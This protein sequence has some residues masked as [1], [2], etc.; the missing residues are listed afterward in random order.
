MKITDSPKPSK[1][2]KSKKVEIV[3]AVAAYTATGA[4]QLSLEVGQLIQVR[5]KTQTGWWEGELQAKGKK[6][7]IGWFPSSYVKPMGSS[8]TSGSSNRNTPEPATTNVP[9]K[10]VNDEPEIGN[11]KKINPLNEKMIT[12]LFHRTCPSPLSI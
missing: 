3:T 2:S 9:N 10:S 11:L 8:G 12:W 6:K 7:Q 5:K 4:E 1:K